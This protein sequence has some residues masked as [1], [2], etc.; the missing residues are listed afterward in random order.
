MSGAIYFLSE[1][2]KAGLIRQATKKLYIRPN[3]THRYQGLSD[4][5]YW[6][7]EHATLTDARPAEVKESD[8]ARISVGYFPY[9]STEETRLP[10]RLVLHPK[11]KDK[12]ILIANQFLITNTRRGLSSLRRDMPSSRISAVLE[13]VGI[14]W[15]LVREK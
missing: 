12:L 3:T 6:I 14:D 15:L 9:W 4:Y 13:A 10:I 11:A 1:E 2:A 8:A 5:I 7:T